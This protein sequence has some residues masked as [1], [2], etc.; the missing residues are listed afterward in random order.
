[1]VDAS[2]ALFAE[3]VALGHGAEDMAAVVRALQ[4][5]TRSLRGR[6]PVQG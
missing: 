5:R 3:A 2:H 1:M 6:L 4:A